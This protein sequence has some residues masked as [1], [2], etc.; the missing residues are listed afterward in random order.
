MKAPN[1]G[2][3]ILQGLVKT[4]NVTCA[5]FIMYPRSSNLEGILQ[6][7]RN[8]F[9][10]E[11]VQHRQIGRAGQI[12]KNLLYAQSFKS[13]DALA[14]R[15]RSA[16]KGGIT[17]SWFEEIWNQSQCCF[18]TIADGAERTSSAVDALVVAPH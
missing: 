5:V 8:E 11:A 17:E 3:G 18:V 1:R 10:G 16:N 12:H 6:Y 14:N 2:R 9:L 13:G 4:V 15:R 7:L